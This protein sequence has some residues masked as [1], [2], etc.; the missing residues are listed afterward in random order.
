MPLAFNMHRLLLFTGFKAE[1][2]AKIKCGMADIE[3]G[4][5]RDAK[6]V[7]QDLPKNMA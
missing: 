4:R 7:M 6:E 3:A 2:A 5:G 1:V